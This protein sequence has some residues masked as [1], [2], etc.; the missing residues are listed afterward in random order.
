MEEKFQFQ[1]IDQTNL[2]MIRRELER[3]WSMYVLEGVKPEKVRPMILDSWRR[4]RELYNVDPGARRSPIS[5]D[6]E[7]LL[8]IREQTEMLLLA[9]PFL[10]ELTRVLRGT[11]HVIAFC[12]AD[13]WVLEVDGDPEL[14]EVL[15]VTQMGATCKE[16]VVGTNAA[17]T[18]LAEK[19]PIQIL[20]AEHYLEVWHPWVGYGVPVVDPI[21]HQPLAVISLGIEA[22]QPQMLLV[23]SMA[24]HAIEQ[25]IGQMQMLKDQQ[26]INDYSTLAAGRLSDG[27]L[28]IDHRGRIIQINPV[29]RRILGWPEAIHT[30]DA[31]PDLKQVL[32]SLLHQPHPPVAPQ[33]HKI[34]CMET[35]RYLDAATF[36]VIREGRT[37]GAVV[38]LPNQGVRS[39]GSASDG[40]QDK[41]G[42]RTNSERPRA[43]YTF[44]YI[45]GEAPEIRQALKLAKLAA[46]NT[47]PVLLAGESGTGKEMF[48]QAIHNASQRA[49]RP[50]V[51][52]N[53]GAIPQQLI[54]AELF[55]YEAGAFTGAKNRGN[56][57][58]V[59]KANGGTLFLDEVSEL[60]PSAQVAL[61]RVLQ[62]ME[63]VRLGSSLPT[64]VD[65]RVIAA[66]K[67]LRREVK[68]QRFRRD[69]YY[70]L[71]VL[72]IE[73]PPL[74]QRREDI[75]ILADAILQSVAME[76]GQHRLTLSPEA[77]EALL[78]YNWPG[79]VRELK[80]VIQRAAIL[81]EGSVIRRGDLLPELNPIT[82]RKH[83]VKRKVGEATTR[84][85]EERERLLMVLRKCSG[86]VSEASRLLGISR[87]TLY[88]KMK[89]YAISKLES[90]GSEE[91]PAISM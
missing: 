7:E 3:E 11:G 64:E 80:N 65:V 69:L 72:T 39:K 23:I 17:G 31:C 1:V 55:G 61:L 79:N 76:V 53:C 18:A 82:I 77:M 13:G 2:S 34:Y 66:A 33:E 52:V 47:L 14:L 68:A 73:L 28:S 46:V 84:T 20:A 87:M 12:D 10:D 88:R 54:E 41:L 30:L 59:E 36:P 40:F 9:R 89:K 32:L 75:P 15:R 63:V 71:N 8:A 85:S 62:E 38:L 70:R 4:C 37:I 86:N 26:I 16:R 60:S 24:A 90:L 48:A 6:E 83:L 22:V 51:A 50:F 49:H 74:H 5:L 25:K 43:K 44:D 67:D 45:L 91:A 57:G 78:T 27:L 81:A 29:A 35:D 58:K 21:T 42:R 19:R 56:A